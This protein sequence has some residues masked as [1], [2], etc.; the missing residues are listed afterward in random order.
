MTA[1]QPEPRHGRGLSVLGHQVGIERPPRVGKTGRLIDD[2]PHMGIVLEPDIGF[3]HPPGDVV[4]S[5][6]PSAGIG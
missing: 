6:A 4:R 5:L 2:Q 3:D 1:T